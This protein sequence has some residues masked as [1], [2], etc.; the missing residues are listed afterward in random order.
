MRKSTTYRDWRLYM[1]GALPYSLDDGHGL[2]EP[3]LRS[4]K[5]MALGFAVACKKFFGFKPGQTLQE[6]SDE[7]KAA[8]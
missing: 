3:G 7:I 1:R 4:E 8:R 5:T 6:F 2:A